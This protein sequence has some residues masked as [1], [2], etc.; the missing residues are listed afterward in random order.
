MLVLAS[1]PDPENAIDSVSPAAM[2]KNSLEDS[3]WTRLPGTINGTTGLV[4]VPLPVSTNAQRFFKIEV[5]N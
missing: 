2:L 3:H 5:T 1:V 4:S